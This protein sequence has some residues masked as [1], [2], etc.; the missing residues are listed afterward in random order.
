MCCQ[1]DDACRNRLVRIADLLAKHHADAPALG[2]R[3]A[4]PGVHRADE[5]RQA[6]QR[7]RQP[8]TSREQGDEDDEPEQP[9]DEAGD[10]EEQCQPRLAGRHQPERIGGQAGARLRCRAGGCG[11]RS[12]YRHVPDSFLGAGPR[13]PLN[14]PGLQTNCHQSTD[15]ASDFEMEASGDSMVGITLPSRSSM[16]RR[17]WTSGDIGP[18]QSVKCVD[19]V[20]RERNGLNAILPEVSW[21]D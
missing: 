4:D 18:E 13:S 17:R 3:A 7:D 5:D 2:L 21:P 12:G 11:C 8:A 6:D 15:Q 16:P 10:H 14:A 20:E 1:K 19:A 9:D